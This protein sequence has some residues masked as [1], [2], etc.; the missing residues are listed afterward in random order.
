MSLDDFPASISGRWS[1]YFYVPKG[2]KKIGLYSAAGAG[3][4]LRPDGSPAVDLGGS[5]RGLFLSVKVPVDMDNQLWKIS[6]ASGKISLLN[7]PPFLAKSPEQLVLPQ[8]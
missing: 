7:V 1:L 2:T 3:Q 8:D 5:R 6:N 4:L